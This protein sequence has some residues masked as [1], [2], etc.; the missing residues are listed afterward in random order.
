MIYDVRHEGAS[1]RVRRDR[2][3]WGVRFTRCAILDDDHVALNFYPSPD[4]RWRRWEDVRKSW[5]LKWAA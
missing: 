1:D 4:P 2:K 3:A 5:I